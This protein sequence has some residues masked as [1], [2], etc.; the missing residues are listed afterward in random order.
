MQFIFYCD[1]MLHPTFHKHH[2]WKHLY[3]SFHKN[4]FFY[5]F[6]VM[7]FLIRFRFCFGFVIRFPPTLTIR[8]P[9]FIAEDS[10]LR[11]RLSLERIFWYI[12]FTKLPT[13]GSNILLKNGM[14]LLNNLPSIPK[15][16]PPRFWY[17]RIIFNPPPLISLD[18]CK[19][20]TS[21]KWCATYWQDETIQINELQRI[22]TYIT[23]LKFKVFKLSRDTCILS[24]IYPKYG[25]ISP[26]N[27][28]I[29][30]SNFQKYLRIYYFHHHY[31][32]DLKGECE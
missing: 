15:R 19:A 21:S 4:P 24:R 14:A 17:I 12:F 16:D 25:L 1:Y 22:Y 13:S 5:F 31:I 3:V 20:N 11:L 6:F 7:G 27:V 26:N 32:P 2:Y 23:R 18:D 30:F 8:D 10:K 9:I 29:F 28:C